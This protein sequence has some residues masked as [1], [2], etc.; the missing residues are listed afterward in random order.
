[1][2]LLGVLEKYGVTSLCAPPTVWR[3]LIQEDLASLK[4]RLRL[5]ELVGAGEP[6]NPEIIE[7]IQHAWG[8]WLRDGFGQ[9]V[10]MRCRVA[11]G[12]QSG[13]GKGSA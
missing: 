12:N 1:P 13:N 5:R 10:S 4:G 2:A 7:Q 11:C 6:L 3:M 8:L 9:S